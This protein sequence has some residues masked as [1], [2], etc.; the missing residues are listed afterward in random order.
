[1]DLTGRHVLITGGSRG[2]G[3]ALTQAMLSSGAHVTSCSRQATPDTLQGLLGTGRLLH[4]ECDVRKAV[5]VERAV[6]W[7]ITRQ[8]PLT[9]C[10]ACAGVRGEPMPVVSPEFLDAEDCWQTNFMGTLYTLRAVARSMID[11]KVASG[12]L[13]AVGSL[14][15][16]TGAVGFSSYS[17]SKS[18]LLGLVRSLAHELATYGTTV[19][20]LN[21]GLIETEMNNDILAKRALSQAITRVR[22]PLRRWG[23]PPDLA[24]VCTYLMSEAS[25]YHTGDVLT[26][27]G[28]YQI[29]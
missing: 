29:S 28:G 5:E 7:A 11:Q 14:L 9:G 27:D 4:L 17:S 19:N 3:L 8:G 1:M 23:A 24:G 2:I 26:I 25:A 13:V 16:R 20:M 15:A 12:R 22:I 10:I 18:A 6:E 21:P